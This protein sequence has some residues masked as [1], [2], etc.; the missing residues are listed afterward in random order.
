[1]ESRSKDITDFLNINPE[2]LI[3]Y[4]KCTICK[5]IFRTP[6]TINEC[7]HTFCKACIHKSFYQNPNKAKCP[8]CDALLGGKPLDTLIYDHSMHTLIN[9]L[10][11]QFEV[12]D[13]KNT[14]KMY[15]V[16]REN[17]YPLPGDPESMKKQ[18]PSIN[19]T[20]LPLKADN[21]LQ[22][23]PRIETTNIQVNPLMDIETFK[24][25]LISKL[26]KMGAK[27]DLNNLIVYYKSIEMRDDFNFKDIE[28]IH[29]FNQGEKVI[30]SYARRLK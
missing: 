17:K 24:K 22:I 25:Y 20:I 30:F 28:K 5:G 21:S 6:Y 13:K 29:K 26:D 3:P 18:R 2:K 12:I 14:E 11:P 4:L 23:L 15:E 10:F 16:F 9:I 27:L 19:I 8:V 1:M 7:M